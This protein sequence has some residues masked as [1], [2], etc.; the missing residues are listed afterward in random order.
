MRIGPGYDIFGLSQTICNNLEHRSIYYH[1]QGTKWENI[2]LDK[3]FNNFYHS[4]SWHFVKSF[5]S[6][7]MNYILSEGTGMARICRNSKYL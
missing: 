4:K 1:K 3:V 7:T 2:Q 5:K 6:D